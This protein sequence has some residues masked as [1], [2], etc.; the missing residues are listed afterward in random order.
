MKFKK[1]T[2]IYADLIQKLKTSG[3]SKSYIARL[4]TEI[5]WLIRKLRASGREKEN[6]REHTCSGIMWHQFLRETALWSCDQ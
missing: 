3:Y 5:S 6:V 4:E 2:D 1:T